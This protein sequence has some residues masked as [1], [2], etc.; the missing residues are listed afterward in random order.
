M[1]SPYGLK[2]Y[3]KYVYAIDRFGE[4]ANASVVIEHLGFIKEKLASFV[5]NL[6]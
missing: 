4:S 3:T 6:L 5:K 1:A 2:G